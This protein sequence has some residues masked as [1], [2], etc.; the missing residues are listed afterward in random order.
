MA[1]WEVPITP[2]QTAMLRRHYELMVSANQTMNLT[3]ITGAID[4]A[5]KHYA[6]S[7]ALLPWTIRE[8]IGV[9]DL[10]DIGTGAGFPSV[11]LA[12]LRPE[13][14]F[15]AI[16]GTGKK[17]EF[18]AGAVRE[19]GLENVRVE[20]VHSD[21]W[22]SN[23]RFDLV[24]TRALAAMAKCVQ[25]AHRRLKRSG[26]LV[27]YK[28]ASMPEEELGEAKSL[29]RE[30]RMEFEAPF[31]YELD[32]NGERLQRTLQIVRRTTQEKP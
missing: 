8:G 5:I 27:A 12:I 20:H 16:D 23:Q 24:V 28:S 11:P 21:H 22:P 19:L 32:L 18:V 30:L 13:W 2:A 3:R 29:C 10:L 4:A 31:H 1:K 9:V 26:K 17:V 6:D 7:L 14:S 15:T 25:A